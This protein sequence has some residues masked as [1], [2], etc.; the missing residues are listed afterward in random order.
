MSGAGPEKLRTSPEFFRT[1]SGIFSGL[2]RSRSGAPVSHPGKIPDKSGI[3][4]DKSGIF[5]DRVRNSA[6][7][8]RSRAGAQIF[9]PGKNRTS[10]D[11]PG[12]VRNPSGPGPECCPQQSQAL[13]LFLI[14]F[15]LLTILINF[16]FCSNSHRIWS[17]HRAAS[18]TP[19]MAD[20][21]HSI[22]FIIPSFQILI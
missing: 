4:Q 6:G 8:V 18:M 13:P 16:I 15:T 21:I 10:P 2:V 20:I 19:R 11:F 7:L 14:P 22:H 1:E 12:Q 9:R 5:Q 17:G 3:L